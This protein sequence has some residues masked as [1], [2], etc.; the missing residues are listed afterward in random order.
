[1]AYLNN[2]AESLSDYFDSDY[3]DKQM[4]IMNEMI[5]RSPADAIGKAKELLES[6]FKHILD[7]EKIEYSN[8]NDIATLQKKVFKFLNLD[9]NENISAKNNQDVKLV[10]SGLNQI[11]KGINSLRNDKGDGHG[12]GANFI[13]LPPR[14]ASVVVGSALTVVSF[15]WETYQDKQK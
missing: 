14:Y 13:E 4:G 7:H 1:M 12:K 3:I 8:S 5:S 11:I 2:V 15:V 10:L 9:S 6:C